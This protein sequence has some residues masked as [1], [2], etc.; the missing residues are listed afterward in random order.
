MGFL[1]PSL[2]L[3]GAPLAPDASGNTGTGVF[4][5]GRE[6]HSDDVAQLRGMGTVVMPGR[7]W[8]DANGSYGAEGSPV[9]IGYL[10]R[11]APASGGGGS[12]H[13][14]STNAGHYGGSDGQGFSYV[15]GPGWSYY[16]G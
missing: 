11:Q 2:H 6:I 1:A 8:L 16:S 7:W 4:I 5:N 9:I 3:G 15:G 10:N 14:W 12:A 13:S